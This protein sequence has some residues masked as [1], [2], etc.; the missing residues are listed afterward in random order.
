[1]KKIIPQDKAMF[2][3][4]CDLIDSYESIRKAAKILGFSAT[5]LSNINRGVTAVTPKLAKMAGWTKKTVWV[6]YD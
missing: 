6:K 3:D 5:F 2:K 1:M 4:V